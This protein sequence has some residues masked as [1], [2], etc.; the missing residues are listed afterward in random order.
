V[1]IA[2][3]TG[4]FMRRA[5]QD[6]GLQPEGFPPPGSAEAIRT[7]S[8]ELAGVKILNPEWA[9]TDWS[10]SR[11]L[12]TYRFWALTGVML[13]SGLGGGI[14]MHHLV[15]MVIDQGHS[16]ETAALVFSLAGMMAAAG[17]L[18]GFLSDRVGREAAFTFVGILNVCSAVSL[19][20]FLEGSQVWTL[21]LYGLTFGLGSGLGSPTITSGA[22]DLFGGRSFG[23]ILG[24]SNICY[25][26]GQ[27]VGAWAGGAIF[28]QTGSY[29]LAV[30]AAIPLFI[31]M[32]S[33]FWVMGPRTVRRIIPPFRSR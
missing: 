14:I 18:S 12:K 21:Y 4:F 27:G 16:R 24:S 6:L 22:A 32:A 3:L 20:I 30:T 9:E 2:P 33:F 8:D 28:D 15:A 17:R 13:T 26:I 25:G 31:L 11:S 5:P 19:L 1:V 23:S 29:R 7:G 10:L